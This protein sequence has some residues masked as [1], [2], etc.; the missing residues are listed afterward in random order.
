LNSSDYQYEQA[1]QMILYQLVYGSSGA[2]FDDSP[3]VGAAG[4]P[5]ISQL[6]VRSGEVLDAI[7]ATNTGTFAG[8]PVKYTLPGHGGTGGDA[9]TVVIPQGDGLVEVSGYTGIWSGQACVLQITLTTRGGRVF[10]PYG[11]MNGASSPVPFHFTA[12]QGQSI[13]AFS[14]STV[15]GGATDIIASLG[16]T[17]A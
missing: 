12:P 16:V 8:H 15:S 13:V 4:S 7:Q 6:V 11:T 10:G 3:I 17:C 5:P 1:Q 9:A 2:A 14:G